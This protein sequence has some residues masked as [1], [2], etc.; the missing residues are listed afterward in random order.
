VSRTSLL[1]AAAVAVAVLVIA[2]AAGG[3]SANDWTRTGD[4]HLRAN[5][6]VE[7]EM[8]YNQALELDPHHAE[9][10]YGK[11]WAL[12]ASGHD[13]LVPPAR[14]LFQRAIDYAPDFYGGYRGLGVLE[15]EAGRIPAAERLLRQ[16]WEKAPE[17]PTVLESL[18]QLY[19]QADRLAEA[20]ELFEAAV[21][22]SPE[23]GELR[24]FMADVALR[25]GDAEAAL[26]QIEQ[27]RASAVSGRR[28]L[29]LLDEG[30]AL[31]RIRQA[32]ALID[33]AKGPSDPALA[34]AL[35]RLDRARSLLDEA[36]R[37]GFETEARPVIQHGLEPLQGRL[38]E[39]VGAAAE[40]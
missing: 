36:T 32:E 20:A 29:Y 15:M 25:A 19:L 27:G 26:E 1:V 17:E 16:A 28:G 38:E 13:E 3:R 12:F 6:L 37:A 33:G 40:P 23:R 30:E 8:A 34:M 39:A 31:I 4:R 11:G 24:R 18:G 7:A 10:I 9:A 22:R 35:Q 2:L 14:Q 5:E 21:A